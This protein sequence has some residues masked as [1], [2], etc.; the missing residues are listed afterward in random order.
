MFDIRDV[1]RVLK[2]EPEKSITWP[3]G[4]AIRDRFL[5]VYER[6]P[7]KQLRRKTSGPG[8]H[9][10]AIYPETFW[11]EAVSVA[12]PIVARIEYDSA[13]QYSLNLE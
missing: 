12:R 11:D 10:L 2:I 9:C 8:G 3:V 1:L 7:D 6:L 5:E 13:R 4:F